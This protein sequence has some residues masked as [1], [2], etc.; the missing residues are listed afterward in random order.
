MD[1]SPGW[2]CPGAVR[3]VTHPRGVSSRRVPGPGAPIKPC[4]R[5]P[6][7]QGTVTHRAAVLVQR[8]QFAPDV[9]RLEV[10]EVLLGFRAG[11]G[12]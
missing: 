6:G 5:E 12:P 2:D 3:A 8:H 9:D 4:P 1:G 11:R 10:V 7:P